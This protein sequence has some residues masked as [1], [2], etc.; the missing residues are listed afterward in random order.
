MMTWTGACAPA[1]QVGGKARADLNHQQHVAGV[2]QRGDLRLAVDGL[3]QPKGR[4]AGE[5]GQQLPR[6]EAAVAVQ[7][8]VADLVEIKGCGI[9]EHQQLDQGRHDH[10]DTGA[11]VPEQGQES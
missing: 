4:R 8:R 2:D 6:R 9:A 10:H 7:H 5:A 11:L 1:G 3:L